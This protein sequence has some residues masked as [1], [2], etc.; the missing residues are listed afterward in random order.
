[1]RLN[2]RLASYRCRYKDGSRPI[3]GACF[4]S[5]CGEL[6]YKERNHRYANV[7]IKWTKE[8]EELNYCFLDTETMIKYFMDLSKL[9]GFRLLSFNS[10]GD[11]YKLQIRIF[12]DKRYFVYVSTFIRYVYE[13]P[14][15]LLT[16]CALHNIKSF[17]GLNSIQIIQLYIALFYSKIG[18]LC[19]CHGKA[20]YA[21]TNM[22]SK[23]MFSLN[24][25]DF[26]RSTHLTFVYTDH[27]G[28]TQLFNTLNTKNLPQIVDGINNLA[29]KYY[30]K[31]EESICRW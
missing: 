26:N 19:H 7:T 16:Y 23:L 24:R 14:F 27:S 4:S 10:Y 31:N 28:L 6:V 30:A 13:F 15:S 25:K 29:N 1:M 8:I 3:S 17:P 5:G 12:P 21:Y 9:L 11:Y 22:N 18:A 2:F 20:N